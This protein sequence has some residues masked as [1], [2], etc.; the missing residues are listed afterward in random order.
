MFMKDRVKA[1]EILHELQ[2]T[3]GMLDETG[4]AGYDQEIEACQEARALCHE[5]QSLFTD[6]VS[7]ACMAKHR[8]EALEELAHIGAK[9]IG[10]KEAK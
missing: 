1:A 6:A 8:K 7:Q 3:I 2:Q 9:L 4:Y 10:A 5:L